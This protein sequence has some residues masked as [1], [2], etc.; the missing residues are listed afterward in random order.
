MCFFCFYLFFAPVAC[1]NAINLYLGWIWIRFIEEKTGPGF[2]WD[3]NPGTL[4]Y[5]TVTPASTPW[6]S[7]NLVPPPPLIIFCAFTVAPLIREY[8]DVK[9]CRGS[10]C[11]AWSSAHQCY[12]TVRGYRHSSRR[13]VGQQPHSR[14]RQW[15]LSIVRP[16]PLP[17]LTLRA[18]QPSVMFK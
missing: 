16:P 8:N 13:T 14:Q 18:L 7:L 11:W 9:W 10:T 4:E 3:S 1:F 17:P 6:R 15:F 12:Y 5:K 2:C